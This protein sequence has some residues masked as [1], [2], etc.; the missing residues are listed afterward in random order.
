MAA[1]QPTDAE[2]PCDSVATPR[3]IGQR[4]GVGTVDMPCWDITLWAAGFHLCGTD[5]EGDLRARFVEV[6]GIQLERYG[7]G[8][9]MGQRISTPHRC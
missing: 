8:P 2:L 6:P 1:E 7:V 4:P 9:Y 3:E 5:Q